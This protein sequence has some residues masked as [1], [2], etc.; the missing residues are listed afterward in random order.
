MNTSFIGSI[1][2]N[3]NRYLGPLLFIPYAEDIA[4]RVSANVQSILELACGTGLVTSQL[5]KKFSKSVKIIATDLNPD[6]ITVAKENVVDTKIEWQTADML[7][8]PFA[9]NSFDCVVCQFGVMFVPDKL[10]AFQEAYRVLKQ[11]GHFIFSTWDRIETCG[12][13]AI[14]NKVIQD[15]FGDKAP[16]FFKT[17]Y[18]MFDPEELIQLLMQSGFLYPK[19]ELVKKNGHAE[20]SMHAA[21]GLVEGNPIY[22]EI[23]SIDPAAVDVLKEKISSQLQAAYGNGALQHSMQ[24]LVGEGVK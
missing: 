14:A 17:P 13:F 4:Q 11:S 15:F 16:T 18:S 24:A 10:K 1:P 22:K 23:I 21:R 6:M 8:L 7:Q 2:A 5:A 3:Y 9:D 12:A 20:T 19:V